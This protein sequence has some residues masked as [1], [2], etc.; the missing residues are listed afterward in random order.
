MVL[1]GIDWDMASRTIPVRASQ[2]ASASFDRTV[3]QSV[4]LRCAL[5]LPQSSLAYCQT[6]RRAGYSLQGRTV[7]N[8][9]RIFTWSELPRGRPVMTDPAPGMADI[10]KS[11]VL[12]L[13]IGSETC[14]VR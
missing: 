4:Q 11:S 2:A 8:S 14:W 7:L 3:V 13:G 5:I 9:V 10:T 12:F 1:E 6:I